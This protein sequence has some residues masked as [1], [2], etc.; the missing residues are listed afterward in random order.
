MNKQIRWAAITFLMVSMFSMAG[1][2][3]W[4]EYMSKS[5]KGQANGSLVDTRYEASNYQVLGMVTAEAE[6]LC[7]LGVY[8]RGT[9]GQA[10]LWKS[11]K[12]QYGERVTGIKDINVS[13][14]YTSILAPVFSEI[15]STYV[16]TA[17]HEK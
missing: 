14:S 4:L 11:A 8:V 2:A 6:S 9:E 3:G 13:Y 15:K 5:T 12:A 17:V 1:C 7:I 16:G 10:L